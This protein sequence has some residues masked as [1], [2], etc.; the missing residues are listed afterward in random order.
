MWRFPLRGL[1]DLGLFVIREFNAPLTSVIVSTS[2]INVLIG[3]HF[4]LKSKMCVCISEIYIAFTFFFFWSQ[5]A[6]VASVSQL[7]V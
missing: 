5:H 2:F 3:S 4:L 6:F 1:V 7:A